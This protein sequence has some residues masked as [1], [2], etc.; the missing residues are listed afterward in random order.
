MKPYP[1]D[2][3]DDQ[4]EK[5]SPYLPERTG[6]GRRPK[7]EIRIIINAIL[8]VVYTGCQWR[9]LPHEYPPWQT[10][11]YHFRKWQKAETWFVMHQALHQDVRKQAGKD[12][13]PTAAIID[14]QSVKTTELATSRG[15]DGHKKVKGRKRHIVVDTLGLLLMVIVHDAN[16]PDGKQAVEVLTNL[17]FWF[18]TIQ[19]IWAD[20]AYRGDLADWLWNTYQCGLEIAITLRTQGFQVI[21]KRWIVERTFSWF[22]W[23]RRLTI[24]YE[25]YAHTAETMIYIAMIRIMLKRLK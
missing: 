2:L 20:G 13:E 5:L 10:V 25:R 8:Y 6:R 12:P 15:F 7:W 17:F 19:L 18:F 16:L 21:P 4:W 11:Y 9:M 14:S 22:G 24:D 3:T 1:T 23:Y